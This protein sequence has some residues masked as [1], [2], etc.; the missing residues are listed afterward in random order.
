MGAPGRWHCWSDNGVCC[1]PVRKS[2]LEMVLRWHSSSNHFCVAWPVVLHAPGYTLYSY[3]DGA[4]GGFRKI[5]TA[6]AWSNPIQDDERER[7]RSETRILGESNVL[8]ICV[9]PC[10][11]LCRVADSIC[12]LRGSY[13]SE[14]LLD[15]SPCC[16]VWSTARLSEC[17]GCLL[18]R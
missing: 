4:Y 12:S 3:N 16:D 5:C 8:A 2:R 11:L 14:Q 1:D 13:C 15:L 6:G 7:E 17:I 10:C 9:L 18:P